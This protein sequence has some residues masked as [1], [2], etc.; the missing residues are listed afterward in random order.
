MEKQSTGLKPTINSIIDNCQLRRVRRYCAG[1]PFPAN[2]S[3]AS[4]IAL[5]Y[6]N[7]NLKNV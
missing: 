2:C 4:E 6:P 3:A 5:L 7:L 1:W